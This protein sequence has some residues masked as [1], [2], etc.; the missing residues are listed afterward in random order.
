M[1]ADRV[2]TELKVHLPS[3]LDGSPVLLAYLHGS[4]VAGCATPS[5]DVD[6]AL[7]LTPTVDLTPYERMQLE[8]D[9]EIAIEDHCNLPPADVRSIDHAPLRVQGEI[10]TH[11]LLLYSADE[12]ARVR[13]EVGI[14]KRYFDFQPVL[15]MVRQAYFTGLAGSKKG[16]T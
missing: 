16:S 13:Y 5:S 11:G 12:E 9:I 3:I 8:L 15:K 6:I 2:I 7:V 10:I 1:E 4:V 14:R